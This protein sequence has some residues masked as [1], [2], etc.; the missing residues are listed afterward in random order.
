MIFA[1][2]DTDM[3]KA[4]YSVVLTPSIREALE[5]AAKK[6]RRSMSSLL[7]KI[8]VDYLDREGIAWEKTETMR[9]GR[10]PKK[11]TKK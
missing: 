1:K 10:P 4:T 3:K 9:R 2:L 5:I 6:D 7:E 8:I 11:V